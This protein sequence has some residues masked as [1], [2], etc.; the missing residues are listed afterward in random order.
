MAVFTDVEGGTYE[1]VMTLM[2]SPIGSG[3]L[4]SIQVNLTLVQ[5]PTAELTAVLNDPENF[6]FDLRE[7]GEPVRIPAT[8]TTGN[9]IRWEAQ[10]FAFDADGGLFVLTSEPSEGTGTEQVDLIL[11]PT[12][13]FINSVRQSGTESAVMGFQDIDHPGNF[14]EIGVDARLSEDAVMAAHDE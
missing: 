1:D 11:T 4:P 2:P 8:V 10:P 6:I 9:T 7:D 3:T 14:T 5:E 12:P 13:A